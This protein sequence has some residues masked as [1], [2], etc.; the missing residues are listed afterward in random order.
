MASSNTVFRFK[1][2]AINQ[3]RTPMKVGTDGVLLGCIAEADEPYDSHINIL[4]IGTGT[5]LV[6]IMLAQRYVNAKVTAVEIDPDATAQAAENSDASPFADRITVEQGDIKEYS[7]VNG[8]KFDLIV[9]NPPYFTES[10]QCPDG[11]RNMAR[12]AVGL[13]YADLMASA[14]D[15]MSPHGRIAIII[16]Y[17]SAAQLNEAAEKVG[18]TMVRQTTIYSNKRKPP[19]RAVCLFASAEKE[20]KEGLT[21]EKNELT[22]LNLDGTNTSEYQE[23]AKDFYLDK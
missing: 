10:L 8:V 18:L 22:L 2:F 23:I 6:A 4:D 3:D 21:L 7:S 20:A 15:L 13:T 16:P 14:A 12:H 17:D 9:S 11:R 1:Q 19:R 5:G